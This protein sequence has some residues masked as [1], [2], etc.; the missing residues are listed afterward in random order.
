VSGQEEWPGYSRPSFQ[1]CS[2]LSSWSATHAGPTVAIE[3]APALIYLRNLSN[4]AYALQ[5]P[6]TILAVGPHPSH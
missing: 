1:A 4:P 3:R 5:E 2:F 6:R